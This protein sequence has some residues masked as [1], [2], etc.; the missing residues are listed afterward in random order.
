MNDSSRQPISLPPRKQPAAA[1]QNLLKSNRNAPARN[2]TESS[3]TG[4]DN[5]ETASSENPSFKPK[6][7]TVYMPED[8]LQRAKAA[9]RHTNGQELDR[10]WSD[11][12]TRA[13]MTEVAR[14]ERL[15]NEGDRFEGGNVKLAPGRRIS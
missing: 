2:E 8:L 12:I 3:A 13:V 7:I 4:S 9:Y 5:A 1:V 11:F 10:T 14:R 15:Y 6:G